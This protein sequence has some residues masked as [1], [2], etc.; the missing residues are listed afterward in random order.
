[1][2]DAREESREQGR[3]EGRD[4]ERDDAEA[5]ADLWESN[6][7][8]LQDRLRRQLEVRGEEKEVERGVVAGLGEDVGVLLRLLDG[9]RRTREEA[10][11]KEG[12]AVEAARGMEGRL[13]Q[14]ETERAMGA[15]REALLQAEVGRLG[16]EWGEERTRWARERAELARAA[17]VE[18]Q[19]GERL[20]KVQ[21]AALQAVHAGAGV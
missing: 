17:E 19:A 20:L 2:E 4:A 10:E 7:A 3:H 14:A 21:L 9:A 11:G 1:M 18:R 13:A 15:A 5:E 6:I 8:T 12:E 16:R